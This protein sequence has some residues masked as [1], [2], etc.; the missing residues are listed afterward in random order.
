VISTLLGG[1]RFKLNEAEDTPL[2]WFM[3]LYQFLIYLIMPVSVGIAVNIEANPRITA[4]IGAL[5]PFC[6]NFAL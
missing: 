3:H 1:Y 5:I 6:I 4:A 2:P